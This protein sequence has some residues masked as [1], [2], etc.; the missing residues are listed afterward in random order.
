MPFTEP[1][2]IPP[3]QQVRLVNEDGRVSSAWYEFIIKLMAWLRRLAA[4]VP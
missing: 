1:P 4:S 3:S 2:P